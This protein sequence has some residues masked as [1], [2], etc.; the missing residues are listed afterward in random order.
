MI[1]VSDDSIRTFLL[2]FFPPKKEKAGFL[3]YESM[4]KHSV[5]VFALFRL[6]DAINI[7]REH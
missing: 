2:K 7:T 3:Q 6:L 5:S 4:A 1:I